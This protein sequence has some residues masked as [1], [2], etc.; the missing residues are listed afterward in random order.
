V[1]GALGA[2]LGAAGAA[3]FALQHRAVSRAQVTNE[4][5]SE[6]GLALPAGLVHHF[7]EVPDGG[8]LHAMERG[9]GRP[10]VLLHGLMLS[11]ALWVHQLR[12]LAGHHRVITIDLSGHGQSLLGT[13][14][15]AHGQLP[16]SAMARLAADVWAVL[17]ALDVRDALVVGHSMGGMTALQLAVDTPPEVLSTRVRGLALVSTTAGPFVGARR[18]PAMGRRSSAA[19][20]RAVL[21]ADRKG[22]HGLPWRD[23]R[24]WVSR[25]G[26]GADAPA[27]QIQF[28]VG[29]HTSGSARVFGELIPSLAAYDVSDRIDRIELPALVIAGSHDRVLPLR[30]ARHLAASLPRAEL[31]ELPR[32][33]HQPM[34]ERRNEF[35][36]LLDE[37]SAKLG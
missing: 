14:G 21:A 23:L 6:E 28:V 9:E 35:N 29:M 34:L 13:G 1:T 5:V 32:C 30:H 2:G 4:A 19:M 22:V 7:V 3:A 26:F 8:R 10:Q 11:S 20:S 15:L 31:V 36:R 27:A 37:F 17:E 18:A 12:D 16:A 25:M 33:G 24:W